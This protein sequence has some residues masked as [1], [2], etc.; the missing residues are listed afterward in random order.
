[1]PYQPTYF[2]HAEVPHGAS[3]HR[4]PRAARTPHT[5]SVRAAVAVRAITSCVLASAVALLCASPALANPVAISAYDVELTPPSGYG[6]WSHTYTG[7]VT[8]SGRG[9]G[10]VNGCSAT[11]PD[12]Q[13]VNE[14]GGAGTINDGAFSSV[15]EDQLLI[16]G[17]DAQGEPFTPT[18][19]LHL[20]QRA[21]VQQ[22]RIFGGGSPFNAIPGALEAATVKIDASAVALSTVQAGDIG[23]LGFAADDILDL[24]GTGLDAVSTSDIVLTDMTAVAQLAGQF[25]ITEVTVDGVGE[26][27]TASALCTQTHQF[28]SGSPAYQGLP[29]KRRAA[30]D[31]LVGAGCA[32]LY[33]IVARLSPQRKASLVTAYKATVD[34]LVRQRLLTAAQAAT[35][36]RLADQL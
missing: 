1:M 35:L 19:T 29:A 23:P 28:V 11:S 15:D 13:L 17:T 8:D 16:A 12:C 27:V 36:K 7:T 24:R 22:I 2:F 4:R 32:H 25:S 18:I 20:A 31:A 34:A 14:R 21:K 3:A 6:G 30:I 26:A 9:L 5:P 10:P 33:A